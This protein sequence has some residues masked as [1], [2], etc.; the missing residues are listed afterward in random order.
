M[1]G[2]IP[3]LL[4]FGKI[5]LSILKCI[6]LMKLVLLLKKNKADQITDKIKEK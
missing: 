1:E 5:I 3:T 2:V 4:A 6:I